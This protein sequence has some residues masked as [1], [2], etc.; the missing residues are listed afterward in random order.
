[1]I[2]TLS[3]AVEVNATPEVVY[4]FF[5]EIEEN[6]TKW[7]PDHVVFR[8]VEGSALKE[9]AIAYSEQY[10]HGSLH[11]MKARFTKV[12]PKRRIEFSW[13]N[14]FQRFFAPRNE[15]TFEPT[16]RGCRFSA[17]HDIR[18]GWVSS[19]M[20]RV[21]RGLDAVRKHLREEGENLK[22]LVETDS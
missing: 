2:L 16:S 12:I 18:L 7:H 11:K 21:K 6:Y 17:E 8:W 1:M 13:V 4:Q 3:H 20:G 19:R 22:R 15:W 5:V 9:G 14:P 10:V